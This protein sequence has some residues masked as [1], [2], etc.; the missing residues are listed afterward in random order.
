[1]VP[2]RSKESYG[3]STISIEA[4]R[5]SVP[6]G[7]RSQLTSQQEVAQ[8]SDEKCMGLGRPHQGRFPLLARAG[9]R[10]SRTRGADLSA[11]GGGS[12]D[13]QG[14]G[15]CGHARRLAHRGRIPEQTCRQAR[16]DLSLRRMFPG[17][18]A[19]TESDLASYGAK[20]GSAPIFVSLVEWADH[21]ITE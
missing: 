10:R 20:C 2:V 11:R 16:A 17:A 5:S 9:A 21:I 7:H 13:A 3:A 12:A 1:M 18:R 14:S 4:G 15:R 8:D 6:G 19:V